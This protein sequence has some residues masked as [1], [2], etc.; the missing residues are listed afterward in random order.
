MKMKNEVQVGDYVEFEYLGTD[1]QLRQRVVTVQYV[2]PHHLEGYDATRHGAYRRFLWQYMSNMEVV[3]AAKP[4]EKDDSFI[5]VGNNFS[6]TIYNKGKNISFADES[7]GLHIHS[8]GVYLW[9][10]EYPHI[11]GEPLTGLEFVQKCAEFFGKKL[12][13]K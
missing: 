12:V 1:G 6:M 8:A 10:N 2:G 7:F 13:D 11:S 4:A 9:N 3:P 5:D